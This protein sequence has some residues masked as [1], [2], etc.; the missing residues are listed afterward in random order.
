VKIAAIPRSAYADGPAPRYTYQQP[1]TISGI[2][3][4]ANLF[5]GT[6]EQYQNETT[7]DFLFIGVKGINQQGC[8]TMDTSCFFNQFPEGRNAIDY[9]PNFLFGDDVFHSG[10][11]GIDLT[12]STWNPLN[13][14]YGTGAALRMGSGGAHK[15]FVMPCNAQQSTDGVN[16]WTKLLNPVQD[17]L[18]PNY[19]YANLKATLE[20]SAIQLCF[21]VQLQ[22]NPC[23]EAV[24]QAATQQWR[25]P[26]RLAARIFIPQG[27]PPNY[28]Q[29][30]DST[31]FHPHR[32]LVEH[33]PVG[34][35]QRMRHPIYT[36]VQ[37]FRLRINNGATRDREL[38][39]T[40]LPID[41]TVPA[42]PVFV[43]PALTTRRLVESVQVFYP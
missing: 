33:I 10:S 35:L 30:C 42:P 31:A 27:K 37:T 29:I 28:E 34:S 1:Y 11:P 24:E 5:T 3:Q 2:P 6:L 38:Q 20:A 25:T 40:Q 18:N 21:F 22:E 8:N 12:H 23:R 36:F 32:T 14:T 7:I 39:A 19:Q 26:I 16:Y 13:Y 15:Q 41:N 17:P 4:A 9:S 43:C